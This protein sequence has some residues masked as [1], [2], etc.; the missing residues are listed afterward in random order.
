MMCGKKMYSTRSI[1]LSTQDGLMETQK[2]GQLQELMNL[3]RKL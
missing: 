2:E 1:W 3:E